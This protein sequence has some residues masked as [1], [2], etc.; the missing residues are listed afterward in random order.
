[1]KVINA[2]TLISQ[3]I[4][5]DKF[6]QMQGTKGERYEQLAEDHNMHPKT[7]QQIIL[8]LTKPTK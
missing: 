4:I 1:M 6:H 2:K 7:I 8:N 3:Y 5:T